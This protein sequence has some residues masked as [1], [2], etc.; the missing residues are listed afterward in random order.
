MKSKVNGQTI[1]WR[2]PP[3][4]QR[5]D[6]TALREALKSHPGRWA[7]VPKKM[8]GGA[9]NKAWAGFEIVQRAGDY[10]ARFVGSKNTTA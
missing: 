10:Y 5:K 9:A 4:M 1:E 3:E 2:T 8:T 6:H 7:V